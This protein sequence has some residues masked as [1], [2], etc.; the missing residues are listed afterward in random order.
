MSW[1]RAARRTKRAPSRL[2]T[3]SSAG[4]PVRRS[5]MRCPRALG[6][7]PRLP[8]GFGHQS[9]GTMTGTRGARCNRGRRRRG[10]P[11]LTGA[12]LREAWSEAESS[13]CVSPLDESRGGTPEGVRA[14]LG[15]RCAQAQRLV[16]LRLSAFCFL[17]FLL[18]FLAS[19]PRPTVSDPALHCRIG[20]TKVGRAVMFLGRA[21]S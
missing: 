19:V 6:S 14:P 20:L 21:C 12:A 3:R 7:S 1:I 11:P 9:A 15:A 5:G 2:L 10:H 8:G 4:D 16:N 17:A 18:L 13:G